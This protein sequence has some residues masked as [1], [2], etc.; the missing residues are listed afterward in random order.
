MQLPRS[1]GCRGRRIGAEAL[2]AET[3]LDVG[4]EPGGKPLTLSLSPE[5]R[6]EGKK[7]PEY[8]GEGKRRT[9]VALQ[10]SIPLTAVF[11]TSYLS[12]HSSAPVLMLVSS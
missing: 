8:G 11:F 9:V 10:S 6:G 5:Y 7:A 12:V 4:E 1:K 2:I 3:V